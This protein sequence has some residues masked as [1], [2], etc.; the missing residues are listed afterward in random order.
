[1]VVLLQELTV[2]RQPKDVLVGLYLVCLKLLYLFTDILNFQFNEKPYYLITPPIEQIRIDSKDA[3]PKELVGKKVVL[4]NL[5]SINFDEDNGY[6]PKNFIDSRGV[7]TV[8]NTFEKLFLSRFKQNLSTRKRVRFYKGLVI[9]LKRS[10]PNYNWKLR[11]ISYILSKIMFTLKF[12]E[13]QIRNLAIRVF[14]DHYYYGGV[15]K[16]IVTQLRPN[17]KKLFS[18]FEKHYVTSC[19]MF[20]S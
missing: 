1:M 13:N 12:N 20:P 17:H 19:S 18:F 2:P 4:K 15:G 14:Y 6:G 16:L 10:L 9:Q 5:K 8:P 7:P 3:I 11:R